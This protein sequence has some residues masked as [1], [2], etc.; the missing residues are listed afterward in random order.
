MKAPV[1]VMKKA[2]LNALGKNDEQPKI[3]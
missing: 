3:K 1:E 2:V